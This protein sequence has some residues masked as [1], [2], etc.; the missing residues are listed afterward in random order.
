MA[1]IRKKKAIFRFYQELNDFLPP[2]KRKKAS[3]YSFLGN[4]S[5]KD[6][7]EAMG[8]PHTEVDLI[9][10]NTEPVGFDYNIKNKDHISVYPVFE[11]LDISSINKLRPQPL[12]KPRFVV[13]VHLG[14]L[15]KK[16]RMLGLD[17]YYKN[18]LQNPQIVKISAD[19]KRVILTK[20]QK[21][22]HN[23]AVTRGYWVRS[24]NPGKQIKEVVD[25]FDLY[26][27]IEP[28]KRCMECN[29]L[30]KKVD[31]P[32]IER[33]LDPK[34]K[35]YYHEF[36]RCSRCSKIYWKGSHFESMKG[37]IDRIL[38]LDKL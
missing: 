19:Q 35:Q 24:T 8:I 21:L 6:A 26:Y 34:T 29:G 30:I 17:T 38:T 20:D 31:K 28:F 5:V 37:Q 10:V 27:S 11:N 32:E 1:N 13:D 36:Y 12:R 2:E 9:V 16:L 4:P 7:I 18:D 14:K 15:A 3:Y 25:R 33:K 22:L 23:N